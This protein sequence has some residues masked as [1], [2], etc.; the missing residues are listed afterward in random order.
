MTGSDQG[1]SDPRL[2]FG[3]GVFAL[4]VYRPFRNI[5]WGEFEPHQNSVRCVVATAWTWQTDRH[6]YVRMHE[7]TATTRRLDGTGFIY[8][9]DQAR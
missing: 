2:I 4:T 8:V 9:M 3:P 5:V 7:P 1:S 6:L